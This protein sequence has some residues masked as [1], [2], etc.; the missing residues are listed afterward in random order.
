MNSSYRV[1]DNLLKAQSSFHTLINIGVR[2]EACTLLLLTKGYVRLLK[3]LIWSRSM[4]SEGG[5]S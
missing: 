5:F 3:A 2:F 1:R 4:G